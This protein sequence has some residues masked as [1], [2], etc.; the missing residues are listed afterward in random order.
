LFL[1]AITYTSPASEHISPPT[2]ESKTVPNSAWHCTQ[3]V[4]Y[5]VACEAAMHR[6]EVTSFSFIPEKTTNQ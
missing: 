2:G 4:L 1:P 6:T 5:T 3:A